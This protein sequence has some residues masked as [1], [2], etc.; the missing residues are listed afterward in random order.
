MNKKE[1][2]KNNLKLVFENLLRFAFNVLFAT[3]FQILFGGENILPGVAICVGLTML[4]YM[5][6]GIRPLTMAGIIMIL[7]TGSGIAAQFALGS[8]WIALPVYFIFVVLIMILT[9]EPLELRVSVSFL[10]CFVFCQA[11]PVPPEAFPGRMAALAAGAALTALVTFLVWR[12][13]GIGENGKTLLGQVRLCFKNKGYILRTGLGLALAMLLGMLMGLKRPMWISIVVMS[14]TQAD[15]ID[16]KKRIL[17]RSLATIFGAAAFAGILIPFIPGRYSMILIL[18]LGYLS[19]FTKEYKYT[20][21]VNAICALNASL[22][23]LQAQEA[24][25][26]RVFCLAVGIGVVL[27]IWGLQNGAVRIREAFSGTLEQQG[28]TAYKSN[29]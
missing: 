5:D 7:Y 17:Y 10:L 25:V 23:V 16:T 8:P 14:L 28:E 9:G 24:V 3:G 1:K 13:K 15:F 2:Y 21:I 19:F 22:I 6:T 4:P 27:A 12:W 18:L 26:A 11:N 29:I 20:Q